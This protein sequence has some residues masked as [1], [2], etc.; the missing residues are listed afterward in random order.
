MEAAK[1]SEEI[2]PEYPK[3]DIKVEIKIKTIKIIEIVLIF[4]LLNEEINN[5]KIISE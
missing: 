1:I 3:T 2:V 5:K 4:L